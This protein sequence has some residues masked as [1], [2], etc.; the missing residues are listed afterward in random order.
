MPSKSK[1]QQRLFGMVRAVQKGEFSGTPSPQVKRMAR[2]ISSD[3]VHDFATT[4]SQDLPAR[5][6]KEAHQV[7]I[8]QED[9][10]RKHPVVRSS[11]PGRFMTREFLLRLAQQGMPIGVEHSFK[12]AGQ[13]GPRPIENLEQVAF[14]VIKAAG[15]MH[16]VQDFMD[17]TKPLKDANPT[18]LS[19]LHR[20]I[21]RD[22]HEFSLARVPKRAAAAL[23]QASKAIAA[24]GEARMK[25]LQDHRNQLREHALQSH[26][27]KEEALGQSS[28]QQA[29]M[30]GK[31]MQ[32]QLQ[33]QMQA[34]KQVQKAQQKAE[35]Q[36][37]KVIQ[38]AIDQAN[39]IKQKTELEKQN[40]Q[41]TTAMSKQKADMDKQMMAQSM[42]MQL[43]T[44][45]MHM[46]QEVEQA[47]QELAANAQGQAGDG[48]L[49]PPPSQVP[50]PGGRLPGQ[51][52]TPEEMKEEE[53]ARKAQGSGSG[54]VRVPAM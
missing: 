39:Q 20:I 41:Q 3:D 43:E 7:T 14:D 10:D 11:S 46:K 49:P 35:Q 6:D 28:E 9:R 25:Q 52:L 18:V 54:P 44:A 2:E 48:T 38:K 30:Q 12:H 24:A 16:V 36:G 53:K 34:Q 33:A 15:F 13:V 23:N 31:I 5:V 29:Q 42:K 32:S 21:P 45:K 4:P 50:I 47:K 26:Q 19:V 51:P 27:E 1:A 22:P 17:G 8:I 37:Q 40:L